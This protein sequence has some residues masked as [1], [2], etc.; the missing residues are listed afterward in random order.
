MEIAPRLARN[1]HEHRDL[2]RCSSLS[3]SDDKATQVIPTLSN[4]V[5]FAGSTALIHSN[6]SILSDVDGK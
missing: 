3:M 1:T 5:T 4:Y 2:P 6:H